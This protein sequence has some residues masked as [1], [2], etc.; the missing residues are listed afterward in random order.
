MLE[1]KANGYPDY[2]PKQQTPTE[3][4]RAELRDRER[5]NELNHDKSEN[6]LKLTSLYKVCVFEVKSQV[7]PTSL[8]SSVK[9]DTPINN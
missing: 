8:P 2:V 3:I 7:L 5:R 1:R 6:L 9:Q 4:L